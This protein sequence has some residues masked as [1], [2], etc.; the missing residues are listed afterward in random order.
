MSTI[1]DPTL[2]DIPLAIEVAEEIV[3]KIEVDP[4]VRDPASAIR[5]FDFVQ[6]VASSTWTVAHNLGYNPDVT[7]YSSGGLEVVA[8]VLHI[9]SNNLTITFSSPFA[10]RARLF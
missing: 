6:A 2:P 3:L 8:E 1:Y 9:D 4:I 7:V 5:P 10:G